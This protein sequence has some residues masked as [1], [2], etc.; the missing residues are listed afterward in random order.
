ML[1]TETNTLKIENRV[2]HEAHRYLHI[3]RAHVLTFFEHGQWWVEDA[4]SGAQWSVCDVADP[5]RLFDF[6]QV[7]I[8]D[9]A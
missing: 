8:G 2:R 6:E 5:I 4:R 3:P 7:T 1:N 9:D